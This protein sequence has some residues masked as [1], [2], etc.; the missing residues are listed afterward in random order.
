VNKLRLIVDLDCDGPG[1]VDTERTISVGDLMNWLWELD[2]CDL[3]NSDAF[4]SAFIDWA[5][6]G[7]VKCG[8]ER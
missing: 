3:F 8:G 4:H 7:K 2:E 1:V 6:P 5:I